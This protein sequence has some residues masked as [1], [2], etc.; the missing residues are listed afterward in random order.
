MLPSIQHLRR[1]DSCGVFQPL[2]M[3]GLDLAVQMIAGHPAI[4]PR[5]AQDCCERTR[6]CV[7]SEASVSWLPTMIGKMAT[8]LFDTPVFLASSFIPETIAFL[9][10]TGFNKA[11]LASDDLRPG[12]LLEPIKPKI[13]G[14]MTLKY[15]ALRRLPF[16]IY[17]PL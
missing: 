13:S 5:E 12:E 10:A 16:L 9:S 2:R 11:N 17:L 6:N 1:H 8:M 15:L 3:A 7:G 4:G 14:L